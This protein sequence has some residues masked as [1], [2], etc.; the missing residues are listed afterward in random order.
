MKV[1]KIYQNYDR[2]K[3]AQVRNYSASVSFSKK[4]PNWSDKITENLANRK[5]LDF[6]R[7]K[8]AWMKGEFGG[9]AMTALGTGL[10]APWPIAFNPFVKAKEGATEAEKEDLKNTK[11]YT[12]WRQPISAVLAAIFQLSALKPIDKFLDYI[13]NTPEYAK[14]F[15]VDTDQ[16]LI[17]NDAFLKRQVEKENPSFS[18]EELKA[19]FKK[20]Q[21]KQIQEVAD[22]LKETH[23]I[24]VGERFID[25]YKVADIVNK[26][27]EEYIKDAKK[28]K[29]DNKGLAFYSQR[30]QV[31]MDHEVYLRELLKNAPED[32]AQ[33]ETYLKNLLSNEKNSDLKLLIGEILDRKPEIRHHRIERTVERIEKI[34][35]LCNGA[36]SF[37]NYME[38]MAKRNSILDKIITKFELAKIKNVE[39]A[40]PEVI[41]KAVKDVIANCHFNKEDSLL[42]SILACT[43]TFQQDKKELIKKVY[44]DIAKGYKTFVKNSYRS[45]NQ[46]VKIAIGVCIT[47]PITCSALNWVYPRFM[48]KFFPELAGA[49]AKQKAREKEVK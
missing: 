35:N 8:L 46:L 24:Q 34:K 37:D 41:E 33:L 43:E 15:D 29:I 9:V 12:A 27:I 17:N 31:L 1:D 4:P 38:A 13:Y 6:M 25:D 11:Y 14:C 20:R 5:V 19:E 3:K 44:K 22:K 18:K 42:N 2:S 7:D 28:L 48:D 45:P 21:N 47:L 36:Y 26:E 40:T 10:V 16:S 30:A 32:N 39:S 23:R 49:K